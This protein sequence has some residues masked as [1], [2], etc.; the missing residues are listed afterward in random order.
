MQ[1]HIDPLGGWSGDMF[2]A[3][4]LDAF[5]DL[6]PEIKAAVAAL[7]LGPQASCRIVPHQDGGLTGRRFTVAAEAEGNEGARHHGHAPHHHAHDGS[8]SH[9]HHHHPADDH[10]HAP[11]RAWADIRA[12]IA[13]APIDR[14]VIDHATGIFALLAKAEATVHGVGEDAVT[15]HEVGAVDSIVDIVAAGM[16]IARLDATRW[17][18]APLPLGGGR[19]RTAHGLLPV[20]APA[21]A[22][23]LRGLDTIDDGIGGERVT[24]TGAAVARYLLGPAAGS[25]VP[26]R[27]LATGIGFG[28]RQLP[29]IANCLRLLA[30]EEA[31]PPAPGGF[32]HR[33]LAVIAFEVDDQ[34]AEDLTHGLDHLRAL[35]GVHDVIQSVAF[36]KKGRMATHV[37]VLVAPGRLEAA[38]AACFSETT[39]I[40]LR[41]HLVQGAALRRK[42]LEVE[43]EGRRLRVKSVE[44]PDGTRTGKTEAADVAAEPGHAARVRLRQAGV[45]AALPPARDE[46]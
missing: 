17:T 42:A 41:H 13:S 38:I 19:V 26:R 18:T 35:E 20:P 44:R 30:F 9:D 6:W 22:L 3:A 10:A 5:P 25:A 36:G 28:T 32:A 43:V 37:Q 29:G 34:S 24:P 40:G 39:T 14:R 11:H 46:R 15:F 4:S 1:V 27:L 21:T 16:I 45:A 23:L 12:L 7:G 31:A 8:H 33:E 2:V